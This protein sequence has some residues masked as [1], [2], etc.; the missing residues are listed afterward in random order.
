MKIPR[1]QRTWRRSVDILHSWVPDY[2]V[3]ASCKRKDYLTGKREVVLVDA[4]EIALISKY[5][6]EWKIYFQGRASDLHI[7]GNGCFFHQ[8]GP[9]EDVVHM[10]RIALS[11]HLVH[12]VQHGVVPFLFDVVDEGWQDSFDI[13]QSPYWGER[14]P[15]SRQ[16]EDEV[17]T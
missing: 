16:D 9:G 6:L 7:V 13:F 8:N 3:H 10:Q 17:D 12:S 15:R 1:S 5:W 2:E 4:V 11:R 14:G